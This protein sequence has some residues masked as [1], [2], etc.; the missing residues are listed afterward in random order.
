M[1]SFN[2]VI[3][4]TSLSSQMILSFSDEAD[5][6][7]RGLCFSPRSDDRVGKRIQVSPPHTS[8]LSAQ[9]HVS[10]CEIILIF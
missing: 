4:E 8:D 9:H 3:R 7:W 1:S 10:K 6:V 5:E 2:V